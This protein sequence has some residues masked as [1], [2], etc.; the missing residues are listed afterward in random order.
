MFLTTVAVA[1]D[2]GDVKAAVRAV[3]TAFNSGDA[4]AVA[5][6]MH[7]E[8][9]RFPDGELLFEGFNKDHLKALFAA[10]LKVDLDTR[11]LGVK[12]Y[13]NTAVATGYTVGTV[14]L[15]DG[16]INQGTG[17]FSEV[18]IKQENE[19]KRVHIHSSPL[20]LGQ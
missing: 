12:I 8:H 6:Y 20:T 7:P 16:T 2:V 10:G 1:D 9:S 17:R 11:H 15:P 5:E 13:G 14:T 4:D 19:W 3:D 18:W